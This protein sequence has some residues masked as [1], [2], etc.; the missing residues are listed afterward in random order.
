MKTNDRPRQKGREIESEW[1]ERQRGRQE[2]NDPIRCVAVLCWRMHGVDIF[3]S[4][5]VA[6][7]INKII[8]STLYLVSAR[9]FYCYLGSK[10][11]YGLN[12]RVK[13]YVDQPMCPNVSL[14][15]SDLKLTKKLNWKVPY[16]A[17]WIRLRLP[18]CWPG[19]KSQAH[20][21]LFYQFIKI[22]LW[23]VEKTKIKRKRGRNWPIF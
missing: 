16:I 18:S 11:Q 21:L 3:A 8:S 9:R 10:I 20:H 5:R 23:H 17:Q 19:F 7:L 13:A 12:F 15:G 22:E 2:C 14:F 4:R 1:T 6:Y